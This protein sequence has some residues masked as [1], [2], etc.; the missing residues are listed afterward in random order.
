VPLSFTSSRDIDL[1]LGEYLSSLSLSVHEYLI[2]R[3]QAYAPPRVQQRKESKGTL[4]SGCLAPHAGIWCALAEVSNTL[5]QR[6]CFHNLEGTNNRFLTLMQR[7]R[8]S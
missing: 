3:A 6:W 4:F 2:T 1:T 7:T 8:R 5:T